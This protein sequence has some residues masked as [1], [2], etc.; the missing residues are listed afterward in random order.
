ME[1]VEGSLG[2][3]VA[4]IGRSNGWG[5]CIC[6]KHDPVSPGVAGS[7]LRVGPGLG[8]LVAR[9]HFGNGG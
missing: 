5:H 6:S 9:G 2:C 3:C 1:L 4:G 8:F 7:G